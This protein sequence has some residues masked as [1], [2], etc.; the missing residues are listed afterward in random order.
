MSFIAPAPDT[1]RARLEHDHWA[2]S[3]I[4]FGM[5]DRQILNNAWMAMVHRAGGTALLP[6]RRS[7]PRRALR[8]PHSR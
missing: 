1:H 2:A 5:P 7:P 8:R 4:S 3:N 6:M